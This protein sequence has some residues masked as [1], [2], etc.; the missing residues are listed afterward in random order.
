MF[1]NKITD[2]QTEAAETQTWLDF[3]ISCGYCE[4]EEYDRLF[5][6][7]DHITAQLK[8]MESRADSFCSPR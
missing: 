5:K 3:I 6:K 2:C 7:Y 8:I 4:Q 1:I